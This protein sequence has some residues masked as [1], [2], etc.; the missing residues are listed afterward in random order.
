[1]AFDVP[2][3]FLVN[4]DFSLEHDE[5]ND[6]RN[7]IVQVSNDTAGVTGNPRVFGVGRDSPATSG[8]FS[9]LVRILEESVGDLYSVQ[10]RA[11]SG[12]LPTAVWVNA[13]ISAVNAGVF[14]G[15]LT[16]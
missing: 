15:D 7:L 14:E 4:I 8:A 6:G 13:E 3:V 11:T 2:G 10:A 9:I 5:D 12:D 16:P 1:M